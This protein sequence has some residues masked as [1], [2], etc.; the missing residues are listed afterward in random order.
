MKNY[1]LKTKN[2]KCKTIIIHGNDIIDAINRAM[3]WYH[4][5]I[6]EE[7]TSAKELKS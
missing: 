3:A 6:E 4:G 5:L 7:I 1:K 2:Q